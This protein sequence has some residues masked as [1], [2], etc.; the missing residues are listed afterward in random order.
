LLGACASNHVAK[1]LASTADTFAA[2]DVPARAYSTITTADAGVDRC[3]A[4]GMAWIVGRPKTEIP[5]TADLSNRWVRSTV[6]QAPPGLAPERLNILYDPATGVV[7]HVQ[8][9]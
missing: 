6:A 7:T 3:G 5:V 2:P 1:P 9:G 4:S 8:C